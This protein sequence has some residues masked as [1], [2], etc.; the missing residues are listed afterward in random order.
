MAKNNKKLLAIFAH[1]DD[2]A[3]MTGGTLALY[4]RRGVSVNLLCATRGEWGDIADEV[5][6]TRGELPQVRER[7][8]KTACKIMGANLLGFLDCPDGGVNNTDWCEVEEKIVRA[9]RAVRPQIIV[10]FGLD[11]LYGHPDHIAVSMLV[12]ASFKSAAQTDC[13][14]HQFAE[15]L[16]SFQADKLY[17]ATYPNFLFPQI[18]DIVSKKNK[19]AHLWGLEAKSFGVPAE[20][21]TTVLDV[22][23]TIELKMRAIRAHKTQFAPDNLF[24]LIDHATARKFLSCEYFRLVN[25]PRGETTEIDL[26]AGIADK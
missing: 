7:E 1:P 12:A 3:I 16:Q 6:I 9:I 4:A 24:S 22:S 17:F 11:G 13:F 18:L 26:F 2:E 15:N 21:I 5:P 14:V 10:T 19:N 8:L 23:E 25:L 20:E